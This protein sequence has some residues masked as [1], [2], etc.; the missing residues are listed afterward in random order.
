MFQA[1]NP[2]RRMRS[3]HRTGRL[4]MAAILASVALGA[5]RADTGTIAHAAPPT[6]RVRS[7]ADGDLFG[8]VMRDPYYEYNTDPVNFK[9]ALEAQA[10]E[11]ADAGVTWVRLEFFADYDGSVPKGE[12][13]F[14]KYDYFINVLAPKYGFKVLALLNVGMVALNGHTL[15][16]TQF[17]DP[18]DRA[19]SDPND[20]SN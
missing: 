10:Q 20:G 16:P 15:R 8:I 3:C 1:K 2:N 4:L 19:G 13:N 7:S 12:I 14:A 11:L 5:F 17:N 18:P 9:T 6:D